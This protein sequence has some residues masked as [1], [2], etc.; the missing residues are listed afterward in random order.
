MFVVVPSVE[1]LRK[2]PT[3]D[4]QEVPPKKL[5]PLLLWKIENIP[6]LFCSGLEQPVLATE[7]KGSRVL[8]V[9]DVKRICGLSPFPRTL[10]GCVIL[11][12]LNCP[13]IQQRS[14]TL[15]WCRG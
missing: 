7:A 12:I 9:T 2:G 6:L 14:Q 3:I 13:G 4:C 1:I 5:D 15:L 10:R 11:N 8:V